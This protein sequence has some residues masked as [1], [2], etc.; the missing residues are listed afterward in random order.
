MHLNSKKYPKHIQRVLQIKCIE[1]L[2]VGR[3]L[4]PEE[5]GQDKKWYLGMTL[6]NR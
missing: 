1:S 3:I 2:K 6:S 5:T 4:L